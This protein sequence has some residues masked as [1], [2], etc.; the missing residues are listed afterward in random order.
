M[1]LNCNFQL[2]FS[3]ITFFLHSKDI[4]NTNSGF[5]FSEEYEQKENIKTK[6]IDRQTNKQRDIE[7]ERQT[8]NRQRDKETERDRQL[9]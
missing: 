3:M 9:S 5:T 2:P 4:L 8:N 6:S 7:T 1:F